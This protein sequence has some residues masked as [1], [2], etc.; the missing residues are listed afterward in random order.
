M[1]PKT[2]AEALRQCISI[3]APFCTADERRT[4]AMSVE[5][6]NNG[7][8]N[9]LLAFRFDHLAKLFYPTNR[10]E[11]QKLAEQM[12]VAADAGKLVTKTLPHQKGAFVSDLATWL[13]C[14]PI[15]N[16]SPLCYWLP[17]KSAPAPMVAE[18]TEQH[19]TLQTS[20]WTLNKP[21]RFQGYTEPLYN[22]L[23]EAHAKGKPKPT[24]HDVLEIF[25]AN[26]PAQVEKVL[27]NEG[28]DYYT[29]IYTST[30]H[31]SLKAIRE[32]IRRMTR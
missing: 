14:P 12:Q 5:K 26:L 29:E 6:R 3:L 28:L 4:M 7:K 11:S 9:W 17:F 32:A 30:K 10:E 15:P 16:D 23:K 31:A 20:S 19:L 22:V 21:E 13:D 18:S 2:E 25:A 24:V 1:A 8:E 27:P